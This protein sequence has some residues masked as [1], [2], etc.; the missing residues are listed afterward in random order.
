MKGF[1]KIFSQVLKQ[2][3]AKF[4][5]NVIIF[6]LFILLSFFSNDARSKVVESNSKVTKNPTLEKNRK[7]PT[8]IKSDIIDIK[9]KSQTVDF[10]GNVVVEKE[11][12]SMIAEKMTVFYE[13]KSKNSSNKNSQNSAIKRINAKGNVRVFNDEFIATGKS[14]YYDPKANIFVLEEDVIVNNGTSV[15]KGGKFIYNITTKRGNFVGNKNE[16]KTKNK[17]NIQDK[18]DKR[19][20]VIIGDDLQAQEKP[21]NKN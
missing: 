17:D 5:G 4:F 13:E 8:T 18:S 10:L 6:T 9:R 20:T 7:T 19:V 21:N 1:G 15:A 16:T 3:F 2:D 12:S 11:D 14:G